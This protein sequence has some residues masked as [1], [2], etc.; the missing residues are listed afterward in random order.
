MRLSVA[1]SVCLNDSVLA[2]KEAMDSIIH[3]TVK[4]DEIILVADGPISD[5]LKSEILMLLNSI[6]SFWKRI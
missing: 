2:F 6:L 3:Q 5:D 4:A 1:I